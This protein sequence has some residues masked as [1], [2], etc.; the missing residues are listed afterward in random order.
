MTTIKK[1]RKC[2]FTDCKNKTKYRWQASLT[3]AMLDICQE[4]FDL[5]D[6]IYEHKK[7]NGIYYSQEK[8]NR[9]QENQK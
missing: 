5:L 4:H 1:R 8:K 9:E 3:K 6:K 2:T 7:V